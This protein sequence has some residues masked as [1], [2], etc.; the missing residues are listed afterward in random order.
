MKYAVPVVAL[1]FLLPQAAHP[2]AVIRG[3]VTTPGGAPSPFATVVVEPLG[4]LALTDRDGGY[5]LTVPFAAA[6]TPRRVSITVL[7][8]G[9]VVAHRSG[10]IAW[11]DTLTAHF[12]LRPDPGWVMGVVRGRRGADLGTDGG[13]VRIRLGGVGTVPDSTSGPIILVDGVLVTGTGR[14]SLGASL[15]QVM[16][17]DEIENIEVLKGAAASALYGARAANGVLLITTRKGRVAR[18][19]DIDARGGRVR[20]SAEF[21]WPPP[22]W[23]TRHDLPTHL[24]EERSHTLGAVF[25]RLREALTRGGFD[26]WSAYPLGEDGFVVVA[27]C[28]VINDRGAPIP[29]R[30]VEPQRRMTW[31]EY[32]RALFVARPG[33]YRIIAFV[34]SP[35][36]VRYRDEPV[37]GTL[38]RM[39]L[40]E[41][42]SLPA[43]LAQRRVSPE[44]HYV[45]L[46]YE[47]YRRGENFS[48]RLV[49]RSPITSVEHLAGARLWTLDEL[50]R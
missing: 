5:R 26:E 32:L 41:S 24:L 37:E 15:W 10:A 14:D 44:T 42:Q 33:R 3:R 43:A 6:I 46:I 12:N 34:V 25:G 17:P 20:W 40:D 28:E 39:A 30:W 2:Q 9:F 27:R 23:T 7:S 4:L 38:A 47:F 13:G 19:F 31:G 8:A 45:A 48:P 16:R 36:H 21:S 22:H 50:R 11:G 18:A 35:R 1:L 29:P 49:T